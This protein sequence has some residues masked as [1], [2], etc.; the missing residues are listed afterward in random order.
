MP[1]GTAADKQAKQEDILWTFIM[2]DG[3][4]GRERTRGRAF[5]TPHSGGGDPIGR[6]YDEL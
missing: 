2:E 4:G 5:L 3:I 6:R 1:R